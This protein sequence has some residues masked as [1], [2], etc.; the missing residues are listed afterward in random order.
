M[1]SWI[2]PLIIGADIRNANEKGILIQANVLKGSHPITGAS[3]KYIILFQTAQ[4]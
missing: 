3:I 1:F 2:I 4:I